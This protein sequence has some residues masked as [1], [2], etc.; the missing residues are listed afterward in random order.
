MSDDLEEERVGAVRVRALGLAAG[1]VALVL[2]AAAVVL[3][4]G[5]RSADAAQS[6]RAGAV[7]AAEQ[8]AV[9]VTSLSGSDADAGVARVLSAATG[10]FRTAYQQQA[11]QLLATL[12]DQQVAASGRVIDSGVVSS[13]DRSAVVVV[14][15]AATVANR[16]QPAPQQ[17]RFRL[18]LGLE[19]AGSQW[20]TS[21][22]E[23][24]R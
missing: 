3:A 1:A 20:L 23:I 22:F 4:L 10:N 8:Q 17:Q 19:R 14:V 15:V 18:Q 16:A 2:V 13:A 9:D 24:L 5:L 7:R 11:G 21:S 12:R 6:A